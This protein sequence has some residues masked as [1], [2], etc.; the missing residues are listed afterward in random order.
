MFGTV[1]NRI[2]ILSVFWAMVQQ[3]GWD[4]QSRQNPEKSRLRLREN[5]AGIFRVFRL[6]QLAQ[7][8]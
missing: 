6:S 3:F 8:R 4:A 7:R 2:G 5:L 1:E